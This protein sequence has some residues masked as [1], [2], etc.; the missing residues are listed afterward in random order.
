M[1]TEHH[2]DKKGPKV[3]NEPVIT[4]DIAEFQNEQKWYFQI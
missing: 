3:E 1:I 2:W 4:L